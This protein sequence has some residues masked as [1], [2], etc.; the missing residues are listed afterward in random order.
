M[1]LWY[2]TSLIVMIM[3][4]ILNIVS[5]PILQH[6]VKHTI[7]VHKTLYVDRN[8]SDDDFDLIV[9]AAYEWHAATKNMVSYDVV[10]LPHQNIDAKN[11]IVIVI[12]SIDF[13]QVIT[14]DTP[15]TISLAYYDDSGTVPYIGLVPDRIQDAMYKTVIMHELGHSLGLKHSD[16]IEGIGTLMYPYIDI[17]SDKITHADLQQF[18]Q[19]YGCDCAKFTR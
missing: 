19:I 10:R 5:T 14:L 2:W 7:P 9:S 15:D 4:A 6:G 13:P 3:L 8:L 1:R 16:I 11:S 18:C 17:G 12:V